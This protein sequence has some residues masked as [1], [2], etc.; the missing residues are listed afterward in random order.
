M[1]F[2]T[3]IILLSISVGFFILGF[4]FLLTSLREGEQKASIW[5]AGTTLTGTILLS[6]SLMLPS[7]GRI[8][9]IGILLGLGLITA[10][11][12]YFPLG[13]E[14]G[15]DSDPHHQVDEREI[16]FA[17][18]RL[19]PDS[20]EY[21]I[22][23]QLHPE[24]QEQDDASRKKPGLLSP[25]AS[26]TEPLHSAA[27]GASFYLTDALREAVDGPVAEQKNDYSPEILTR[28]VKQLTKYYG[29]LDCGITILKSAHIYSHIGR[30]SGKYGA[31]VELKHKF[32]IAFVVEMDY[33]MIG[34]APY[35]PVTMESGRQYVELARVAVQ[36]AAAIRS[37]GFPA[38]AHIDGNY[39]VI[40]PLVARDAGLGEIGRMGLLMT[41]HQGPRVRVGVVT[42]DMP[43]IA[44]NY[45]ANVSLIDFC[46]IC[47]KC[48]DNCPS[49]SI[50]HGDREVNNGVV[51]WKISPESCYHYWTII[52]TDC[53]RCLAVCPYSHPDNWAHNIV[54]W[55]I[56]KS[57]TFRRAA[58]VLDDFLYGKTPGS[59]SKS[60]LPSGSIKQP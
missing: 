57:G 11:V 6:S 52:G 42:T 36:L 60:V 29:A 14:S 49:Q 32:A 46:N 21:E 7:Q 19:I 53:G 38:R 2:A 9:L 8:V 23:Y 40:A 43:L 3:T 37:L 54:R 20:P 51:R 26:Y 10:L 55:G 24:H 17:R 33:Q 13:K 1:S 47:Q 39:R 15:E 45:Q 12:F 35:P 18:A 30:G 16:I 59:K 25:Q 50:P 28:T 5:S 22:Y 41:P 48:A 4:A 56:S 58:L 31:P 27:A 34:S 44:D